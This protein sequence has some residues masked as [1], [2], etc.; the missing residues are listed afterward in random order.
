MPFLWPSGAWFLRSCLSCLVLALLSFLC[1]SRQQWVHLWTTWTV[2]MHRMNS[3]NG[4]QKNTV[5]MNS[6]NSQQVNTHVVRM[7]SV[8]SQQGS[9]HANRI[10]SMSSQQRNKQNEQ[11]EQS[12]IK[13][14]CKENEQCE[15]NKETHTMNIVNSQQGNKHKEQREQS[16]RKHTQ[17]TAWTVNMETHS[18]S[19][20][21][22]WT[23]DKETHRINSVNSQQG[24][25]HN[26]QHEQFNKETHRNEW[27][28]AGEVDK[29]EKI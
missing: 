16:A 12:T 8:N 15:V 5:K 6:M 17:W 25:T 1:A 3:V 20:W 21:T 10:N 9:M 2:E 7:N 26:E 11:Y 18:Q 27:T 29:T 22:A 13:H 24:K 19:E 4:Q 23:V 28:T 14:A